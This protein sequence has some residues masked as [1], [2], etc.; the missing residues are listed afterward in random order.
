VHAPVILDNRLQ[1][2][3]LGIGTFLD[4]LTPEVRKLGITV[5]ELAQTRD[6]LATNQLELGVGMGFR[7]LGFSFNPRVAG[8]KLDQVVHYAGNS[9]SAQKWP[10]SILTVHDLF[11]SESKRAAGKVQWMLLKRGLLH[12]STLVAVSSRTADAMVHWGVPAKRIVVIPHGMRLPSGQVAGRS[13][14]VAFT[15]ASPRKRPELL[16]SVVEEIRRSGDNQPITVVARGGITDAHRLR[17][18]ANEVKVETG[19]LATEVSRL[20]RQSRC[21]IVTSEEE[22]FGLPIV[23]AAEARLPVVIAPDSKVAAEAL[24][25]HCVRAASLAGRDWLEALEKAADVQMSSMAAFLPTW[26]QIAKNYVE[27]YR[28]LE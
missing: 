5:V 9:A 11:Q 28:A 23:E 17:L 18:Q 13:G 27:L 12:C 26:E 6:T 2:R 19:L 4:K 15:G 3:G 8:V 21:L 7:N 25:P 24:G 10:R 22:G 16:C 20:L 14:Y 1:A